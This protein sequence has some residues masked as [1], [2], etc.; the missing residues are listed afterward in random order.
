M[1]EAI[2]LGGK[3]EPAAIRDALENK[4]RLEGFLGKFACTPQ[5]HQAAPVDFMRPMTLKNGE[6]V[7][8]TPPKK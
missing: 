2:K 7:P 5:D 1:M 3:A 6:Y 4:V 8:Y